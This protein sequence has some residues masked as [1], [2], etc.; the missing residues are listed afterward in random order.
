MGIP[1]VVLRPTVEKSAPPILLSL[2]IGSRAF[3]V[4]SVRQQDEQGGAAKLAFVLM[5]LEFKSEVQHLEPAQR[6]RLVSDSQGIFAAS[7]SI[8]SPLTQVD[9]P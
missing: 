7:Y 9:A 1:T 4:S 6:L 2:S 5:V 8:P 3:R